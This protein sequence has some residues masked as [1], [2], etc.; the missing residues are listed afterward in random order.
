V[1]TNRSHAVG[2]DLGTTYSC[3][4]YLNEHGE[5]VTLANQEGELATPSVVFFDED[6]QVI[7]GT[8]AL[9]NAIV[10]PDRVVQN[11]KRHIGD[12]DHH[13]MIDDQSY[14]PVDIASYIL[15]KLLA[16]A[17]EQIGAVQR[18]VVT[19]PAGFSDAQRRATIEAGHRAGLTEVDIINE[20]V[21]AALCYVLGTEGL[22]FTELAD[23]QR[24]LV[25]DLG[26]GTFDLSLV[27]YQKDE[28]CVVASSGD[29]RLG[30][31][32]WNEYLE[33]AICER[34]IADFGADPRQDP[35]SRQALA[36]EIE[37][38]KRSLSVRPRAALTVQHDSN[39]KTYQVQQQKFAELTSPLVERTATITQAMLADNK[40]GWAHVDVILTTG[41][42]SRMPMVRDRLKELGG[43][44]LN[45][46]LS[47]DQSIA[48]G[49]TYYAGM[50]MT[51]TEF[52]KAIDNNEVADRLARMKQVSVNARGL[53]I[54]I[55]NQKK[56]R[57]P[58][59]LIPPNTSLPTKITQT[60]GTVVNN[61]KRV[62]LQI[63]ESPATE[64]RPHAP[65]GACI[66]DDLSPNLP[67]GA[68][69]AVTI[70]YDEQARVH[71]TAVDV[72]GGQEASIEIIRPENVTATPGEQHSTETDAQQPQNGSNRAT[73]SVDDFQIEEWTDS[74]SAAEVQLPDDDVD[75]LD[76]TT[77]DTTHPTQKPKPKPKQRSETRNKPKRRR[78]PV[79]PKSNTSG[80]DSKQQP[81]NQQNLKPPPLPPGLDSVHGTGSGEDEFWNLP[82]S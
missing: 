30:G 77:T 63:V 41:G 75:I 60:F 61:Q 40:M 21:A 2:I 4:A 62:H 42:A 25:Y 19:V 73:E 52:A 8:E 10:R 39:R 28:V 66:I 38:T 12:P 14:T 31:I 32:D 20:P 36:L 9:R 59:Y 48:H 47:P 76:L 43:R 33:T 53:G 72:T 26:G 27:K 46:S 17:H 37:T 74:T 18:A 55:Q 54:L 58:H 16:A 70:A 49:A 51:N 80:D 13:W 56:L 65:L 11:S 5:P 45:T 24:I 29:L 3:L 67:E 6:Q 22:W 23:E 79:T 78:K 34:F 64:G 71:V 7:V 68:E 50:L 44:T 81:T 15:R 1:N 35:S 69:I 57:I 82:E